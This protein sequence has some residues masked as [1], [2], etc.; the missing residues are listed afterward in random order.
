MTIAL[1]VE[2]EKKHIIWSKRE[3]QRAER[4]F[5]ETVAESDSEINAA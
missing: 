4:T 1:S 2:R 5:S 3:K